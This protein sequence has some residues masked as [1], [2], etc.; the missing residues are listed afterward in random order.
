MHVQQYL[1][2]AIYTL[3]NVKPRLNSIRNLLCIMQCRLH[4]L[5]ASDSNIGWVLVTMSM[6]RVD[7]QSF[8]IFSTMRY[9]GVTQLNFKHRQTKY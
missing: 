8:N 9:C 2:S 5:S 1:Q 6:R 4:V 7:T 3:H